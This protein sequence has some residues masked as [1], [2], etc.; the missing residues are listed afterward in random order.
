MSSFSE[1][2]LDRHVVSR[3][4]E[5]GITV[6]SP[7]Q[8]EALPHAL[9]GKD[10]LGRARTGTGKTLAFALP[11]VT[12]LEASRER[13]RAPRAIVLA[14]T[15]ELAKQV[16]KE[17]VLLGVL[18]I[19]EVYGGTGYGPQEKALAR[20]VDVVVGTPGRVNDLLE[21]RNLV[22]DQVEIVVLDE[23]DEMLSMGFQ[24]Q[25][26]KILKYAPKEKQT[27]L[28]SATLPRW[29][30]K[31]AQKYQN[32]PITI[33]LVGGE[34]ALQSSSVQ[35][36]AI[37]IT[38][39]QRTKVLADLITVLAPERA[40]IFTR[41]KRDCDALAL[42][43]VHRGLEAEAIHGDLAQAQRE[44]ALEAFRAG[45]ARVLVATD[46]AAR[47]LDIP[48]IELV[49]QHHFPQDTEA[50]VHRSGRTGRAGRAG[51]AV[52]LYTAREERELK[53]L[54]HE[55][56]AHF[57]R[58]EAPKPMDVQTAAAKNAAL[59]VRRIPETVIG[60]F[61]SEAQALHD[62]F[63][64]DALARALAYIAGVHVAPKPASLITGEEGFTTLL[65]RGERLNIGRTVAI[66]AQASDANS[67][68]FG[69]VRLVRGGTVA[70]LPNNLV[71]K[72]LEQDLGD[73]TVEVATELPE[74][75]DEG[76]RGDSRDGGRDG[77]NK[78]RGNFGWRD[79][80]QRPFA[81]SDRPRS[82]GPRTDSRGGGN[83]G[84]RSGGTSGGYQGNRNDAGRS[85]GPTTSTSASAPREAGP[86][87][88]TST[89]RPRSDDN[90]RGSGPREGK[91]RSRR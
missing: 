40:I 45:R 50:Y 88:G 76:S 59:D 87:T 22:L 3:L 37:R 15:R 32:A 65:L 14:P 39:N 91:F 34:T 43:L 5:R 35:H 26:E 10:V 82:D 30:M 69:K 64:I 41:T 80:P 17:F 16:A 38:P 21:R 83:G 48:D 46:V 44:R 8:A 4:E 67:K 9:A 81:Q 66:L 55:V 28:F 63:G 29:V 19:L 7:I 20:G 89:S 71:A 51:T 24:E 53:N 42:E 72:V 86:N 54:E 12:R 36:I 90:R 58:Q 85:R 74:I 33:D 75:I 57:T 31:L 84:A 68:V 23:A 2:S 47:G 49:V 60:S 11:I 27:M 79:R 13:G 78:R 61:R 25:V 56:G 73:V 77:G 62:E 18:E 52:V 1:Y 6:P 70:D